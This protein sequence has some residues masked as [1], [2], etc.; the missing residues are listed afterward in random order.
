MELEQS[1]R[2]VSRLG[3]ELEAQLQLDAR[4]YP[5]LNTRRGA[6]DGRPHVDHR[7]RTQH[8]QPVHS[9]R[10]DDHVR[11]PVEIHVHACRQ[12]MAERPQRLD[13]R[14]QLA[15]VDSLGRLGL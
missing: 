7:P 10:S 8:H 4:R 2:P 13:Q 11:I 12:G 15:G 1:D 6:L 9:E 14:R 5:R 3:G